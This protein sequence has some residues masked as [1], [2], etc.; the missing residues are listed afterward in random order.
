MPTVKYPNLDWNIYII[1]I[2]IVY[3]RKLI[4]LTMAGNHP[5]VGG[6]V[7]FLIS[8]NAGCTCMS[9]IL[10]KD[11]NSTSKRKSTEGKFQIPTVFC[12]S[13][14]IIIYIPTSA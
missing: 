2:V 8:M 13:E 6:L 14:H 7:L 5:R 10:N 1:N 9:N 3:F 4:I 12:L 11:T